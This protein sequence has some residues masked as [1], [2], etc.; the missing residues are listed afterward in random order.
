M[1]TARVVSLFAQ[2]L[3]VSYLGFEMGGILDTRRADLGAS[4]NDI[5]YRKLCDFMKA[6]P[7]IAGDPSRLK[8]DGDGIMHLVRDF[9]LATLRNEDRRAAL[10]SAVNSRQNV[11]FSKHENAAAIISTM[12]GYYSRTSPTSKVNRL[13][14]LRDLAQQQAMDLQQAYTDDDRLGVVR[15]T[16][17]SM[18]SGSTT[19]GDAQRLSNFSQH[20]VPLVVGSGVMLPKLLVPPGSADYSKVRFKSKGV[21]NT[22]L[23]A[24]ISF[25]E[26][27][28]SGWATGTQ[29]AQHTDYEY[30]T[31]YLEARARNNR[32]QISLMDQRFESYMFEQNVPHLEQIF[33][34]ELASIDNDV[35]QL[36]IALLRSFLISPVP[37][38]VTGIYKNPGDA[39]SAGE[40]VVRVEYN[41]VVHLA[42]TLVSY[43]AIPL[44]ATATVTSTVGGAGKPP[45]TVTGKVI[46]A[47]GQASAGRWDVVL[48]ADNVDGAGNYVLPLNYWFDPEYTDVTFV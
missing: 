42:A 5:P 17:S 2:P 18:Q 41:Q 24:G 9:S 19:G 13:E 6:T 39:V 43:D 37:G 3:H 31:P 15:T 8:H 11:Y 35:Y 21:S 10:N 36:Q 40:P 12:R 16:E 26:S 25:E 45:T 1:G 33:K 20:S 27:R 7:T 46:A 47:R 44:G 28:N 38:V 48:E 32:A 22:A 29:S 30:R 34:N 14:T 4:V 23:T